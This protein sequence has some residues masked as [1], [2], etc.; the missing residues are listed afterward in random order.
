MAEL[1]FSRSLYR[2]DAVQT[3]ART[4]EKLARVEVRVEEDQVVVVLDD[5]HPA[6]AHKLAD[7]LANH[8][9]HHTIVA[10]REI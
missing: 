9:L 5:P 6:L 2:P 7:E 3:A 1:T 10:E 4:F 8:A